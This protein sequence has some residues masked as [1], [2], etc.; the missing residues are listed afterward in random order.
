MKK[1]IKRAPLIFSW[2]NPTCMAVSVFFLEQVYME[3]KDNSIQLRETSLQISLLQQDMIRVKDKLQ[4]TDNLKEKKIPITDGVC[5]K[6][7][8]RGNI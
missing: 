8:P 2:I 4:L 1:R 5:Q 3:I 6:D 7:N